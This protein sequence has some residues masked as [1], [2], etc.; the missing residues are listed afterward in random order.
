MLS[1]EDYR[2]YLDQITNVEKTMMNV[3]QDCVSRVE[4]GAMK[5]IFSK[6]VSDEKRHAVIVTN[7][8]E[9]MGL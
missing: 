1:K 2:D 7:L 8:I 5:K 4:D 9:L 3:Y 6:L